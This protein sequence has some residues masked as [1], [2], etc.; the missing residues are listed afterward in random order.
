MKKILVTNIEH[1]FAD[2]S[3][4]KIQIDIPAGNSLLVEIEKTESN[5]PVSTNVYVLLR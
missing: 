3:S 5:G 2:A 1:D 4:K